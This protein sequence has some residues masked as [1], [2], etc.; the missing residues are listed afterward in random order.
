MEKDT[1][2]IEEFIASLED[3]QPTVCLISC[4]YYII[5]IFRRSQMKFQHTILIEQDLCV[6]TLKCM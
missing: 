3:Y 1:P 5:S 6:L 4:F 2:E